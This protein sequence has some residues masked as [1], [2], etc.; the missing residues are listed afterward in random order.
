M[1]SFRATVVTVVART[2]I[3]VAVVGA[4]ILGPEPDEM[5]VLAAVDDRPMVAGAS[6]GGP[7]TAWK[8]VV[9]GVDGPAA[10]A[11]GRAGGAG[12]T[13]TADAFVGTLELVWANAECTT[14]SARPT[15]TARTRPTET[16]G[17]TPGPIDRPLPHSGRT[18]V[19]A[20]A[21][22]AV[23]GTADTPLH[24]SDKAPWSVGASRP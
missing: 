22:R 14:T 9:A 1:V 11:E 24:R 18:A 8:R 5:G 10:D 23:R 2:L 15:E 21:S 12:A 7:A 19:Q 20:T 4:V 17:A 16:A 6:P 3:G 13:D